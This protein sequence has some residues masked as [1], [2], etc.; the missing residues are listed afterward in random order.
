MRIYV[1]I[2]QHAQI[3]R[4]LMEW[5][6]WLNQI[7]NYIEEHLTGEINYEQLGQIA[8]RSTYHYRRMFTYMA[9]IT[10]AE[11]I[12][13]R[14]MSLATVDL[15]GNCHVIAFPK[16]PLGVCLSR[17]KHP[18]QCQIRKRHKISTSIQQP[19]N[20]SIYSRILIRS[21]AVIYGLW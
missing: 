17:N 2:A 12:R 18:P 21:F 11:Y 9:D 5:V 14:K 10:P 4:Y 13:R 15:Q 1:H 7:L 3:M 16:W 19:Q 6:E 20:Y 8:C